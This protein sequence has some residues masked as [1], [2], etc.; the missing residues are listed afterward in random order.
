MRRIKALAVL[1]LCAALAGCSILPKEEVRRKAPLLVETETEKF[2]FSYVTRGDLELTQR[3]SCTYVPIQKIN[4]NF[5]VSG[6]YVDAMFVQTGDIVK[7]GQILAQLRM[8]GVQENI[9]TLN[10]NINLTKVSMQHLEE[11]RAIALERQKILYAADEEKLAEAIDSVNKSYDERKAGYE[12]AL[13]LY[14]ME[15]Q[16]A[17]DVKRQRQIIAPI[18]GTVTYARKYSESSISD[19]TERALTVVDS[20]MSLFSASTDNWHLFNVGDEYIITCKKTDYAAVVA[21]PIELG[22]DPGEREMGKKGNVYFTLVTP[23]LELEDNDKGSLT[24]ILDARY[25]VLTVHQDA[26]S[27]ANEDAIV[28]VL[29]EEGM[30]SYKKVKVGLKAGKYYEVIEGLEEGEEVI[31]G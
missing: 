7:K 8:D 30:K 3:V 18:D 25:D 1:V 11:M 12:N 15:L 13:Y 22:I 14:E 10:Y 21:D 29:N 17:Y 4:L 31:V 5:G 19:E 23:A 9:D 2:E 24:L 27:S 20:T 16:A 26:I 28:Y 6:Q